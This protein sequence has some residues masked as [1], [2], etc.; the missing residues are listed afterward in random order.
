MKGENVT[1]LTQHCLLPTKRLTPYWF[2]FYRHG[3]QYSSIGSMQNPKS[4]CLRRHLVLT[5]ICLSGQSI[6]LW[7]KQRVSL[8][9]CDMAKPCAKIVFSFPGQK[10]AALSQYP[11]LPGRPTTFSKWGTYT[12]TCFQPFSNTRIYRRWICLSLQLMSQGND[13]R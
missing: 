2:Q 11:C 10:C 5:H 7:N 12:L 13:H 9:P 4:P 8:S 3:G 1:F 6:P